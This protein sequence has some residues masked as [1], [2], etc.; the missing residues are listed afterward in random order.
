MTKPLNLQLDRSAKASLTEQI[1]KGITAAIES[2]VL[3]PGA[4][5]PS[6]LDLA[7]QLGVARGTVRSAYEKLSAAQL[8]VA[9]RA[10]GTHVA[11]R[12]SII[13]R[14]EETPNPGS[15]M[16]M[17]QEL[18][19]GPAIFQMG[20]PAQE[21][22]PAKLFARIRSSAVRAELSAPAIYPDPRG[23]LEL[24]R[25]IAA[26]LAIARGIECSPSQIIITGGFSSGLGLALRVRGL[27]GRKAWVENPGFPFTRRGLELAGL[28]LA[29]IPVDADGMDVDYGLNHAPDA[30]LVVVTP[31]QQAPLGFTLS[32]ARRLRLLDWAAQQGA[33][34]VEDD[35]LSELQLKGRATPA[36]ASLDRAGRVIHI[37]SF[38][39]TLTPAL[40]LG[41]LVAPLPL[42]NRFAEVAACLA[43]APGPAVQLATAAFMRDGH[44]MRHLRRT[45]RVYATQ[46]DAL[47]KCLRPRAKDVVIAG[48]GVLL[49]L[50][51]GAPD[52]SIARETLPF[53]LAPTPLS[54]WYA[55]TASARSGLLLGIAMSPPKRIDASCDRLIRVIDRVR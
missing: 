12:L 44:Y 13:V 39:K 27:E 43:P 2:G 14:R 51:D 37:G 46:G 41:F 53:G 49:R 10:T 28:S 4:R 52:L 54:L 19:A 33:W 32:L 11:D 24:R 38:S 9:S 30:A 23:E 36:L 17:Y 50:P 26:Y 29:P 45:K 18:T 3:A 22:I 31:G 7:A 42:A 1:R 8:I 35:Y 47:L 6:W 48:L 34:V 20:V 40:R 15:F 5:L 55:S 16:E 21:A 25:E